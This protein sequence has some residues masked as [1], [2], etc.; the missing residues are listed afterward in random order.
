[1]MS[2]FEI[3]ETVV[4]KAKLKRTNR[5]TLAISVLPDGTLELIAPAKASEAL[6]LAKVL[7]RKAW[8]MT[9]RRA[10]MEINAVRPPSRY[11][12]GATHRYL[13]RQ[14]RLKITQAE[15][16]SVSL[17][18]GYFEMQ[19]PQLDPVSVKK[20]LT[21]WFR[22]RAKEQF[23]RRLERWN[24]WCR[25]RRLPEPRLRLL[26]MPKRWGSALKDGTVCLNPELIKAPS[27]CVDYVI[28]H[29]VCHLRHPDHGRAF[30]NLLRQVCP[31][32]KQLKQRLE[33]G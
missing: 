2:E 20:A 33:E 31:N 29:E 13:G 19:V 21:Q 12:S 8:I 32:W 1:M 18:G 10:F 16:A 5:K 11:L 14:Y 9:Q 26:S 22:H 6:I 15:T 30:W 4:G 7:K 25:Q 24:E 23:T 17:R 27:V 28:A 3:I